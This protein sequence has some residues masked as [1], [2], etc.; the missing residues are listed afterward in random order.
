M[1]LAKPCGAEPLNCE[2]LLHLVAK[3]AVPA[4][5][6]RRNRQIFRQG[7]NPED[8][9]RFRRDPRNQRLR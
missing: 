9:A 1:K 6:T 4:S 7:T 5:R 8:F 3:A 2:T